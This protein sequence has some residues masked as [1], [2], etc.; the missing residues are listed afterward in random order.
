VISNQ[1]TAR[2]KPSS[3]IPTQ[4]QSPALVIQEILAELMLRS[5]SIAAENGVSRL[6]PIFSMVKVEHRWSKPK[7]SRRDARS[8]QA[9]LTRPPLTAQIRLQR[10]ACVCDFAEAGMA[11]M[12][13]NENQT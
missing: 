7:R 13:A 2:L 8:D 6:R 4:R 3:F 5:M 1:V 9:V 11:F 10:H 12:Y